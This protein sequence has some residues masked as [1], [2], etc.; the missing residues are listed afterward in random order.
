MKSLTIVLFVMSALLVGFW[1]L[2]KYDDL[3]AVKQD[4]TTEELNKKTKQ[5][6]LKN[7]QEKEA[8]ANEDKERLLKL[9]PRHMN[10]VQVMNDVRSL[11]EGSRFTFDGMSFSEGAVG[12]LGAEEIT[13]SVSV[14]GSKKKLV[15]LLQAIE[16]NARFLSMSNFSISS[17]TADSGSEFVSLALSLQALYQAK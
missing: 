9:V 15:E 2:P 10:Q 14:T 5:L 4:I 8:K 7:L 16:T 13:T 17:S 6:Q 1:A 12:D 11:V 3:Q